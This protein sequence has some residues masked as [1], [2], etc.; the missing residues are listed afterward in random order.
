MNNCLLRG[1]RK[2]KEHY[3]N[4]SSIL[5]EIKLPLCFFK[6]FA[7]QKSPI[8]GSNMTSRRLS[9]HK[10]RHIWGWTE[11]VTTITRLGTNMSSAS[12]KKNPFNIMT[13]LQF[14]QRTKNRL[15]GIPKM[16]SALSEWIQLN[17]PI[18][19]QLHHIKSTDGRS[20]EKMR[21]LNSS[22]SQPRRAFRREAR[23]DGGPSKVLNAL[24]FW[25]WLAIITLTFPSI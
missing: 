6:G 22:F 7:R 20:G 4:P 24:R 5:S 17:R 23:N 12:E 15:M 10:M 1:L 3:G 11:T 21:Y 9:H 2:N 14:L 25:F 8:L 16:L 19:K 13:S 18:L